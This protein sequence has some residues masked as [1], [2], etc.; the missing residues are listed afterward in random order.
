ML[1]CAMSAR[2]WDSSA[3]KG[4]RYAN[5]RS[6]LVV[7]CLYPS[8]NQRTDASWSGSF[9][10]GIKSGDMEAVLTNLDQLGRVAS[11]Q[12]S[13]VGLGDLSRI[14]PNALG[15]LDLILAEKAAIRPAPERAGDTIRARLRDGMAGLYTSAGLITYG[16]I[17]LAP[18]LLVVILLAWLVTRVWRR[19]SVAAAVKTA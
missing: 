1:A 16:L 6:K 12:I 9:R 5:S 4:R 19:R 11:R 13:G 2:L 18:W 3:A 7:S 17:V 14:D 8:S 10:I 15:V